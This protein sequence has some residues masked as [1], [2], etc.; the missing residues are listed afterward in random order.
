MG[1]FNDIWVF[2]EMSENEPKL[3]SL[4]LL[5][6]AREL[7][8]ESGS[9]A[10]PVICPNASEHSPET[11]INAL[12]TAIEEGCPSAL[13]FGSTPL[14]REVSAGLSAVMNL[15]I[16]SDCTNVIYRESD[17]DL[18]FIRPAFDG[19]LYASVSLDTSPQLGTFSTGIFPL[20]DDAPDIQTNAR[21]LSLASDE[22]AVRARLVKFIED[23][24]LADSNIEEA[25]ILVA[26]GRGVGSAEGFDKLRELALLLGGNIAAS[27][28]A[29]EEGWISRD[30]QVGATGKTVT[31]KI[32][33]AC[34]I[35][36]AVPHVVGMKDSET[37]IAINTDPTAPIFDVAHYGIVGDLHKVIPELIEIFKQTK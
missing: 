18:L 21:T 34:G 31:P 27:R 3:V 37:I 16:A 15:G 6:K 10:I 8:E 4:E 11:I 17:T 23:A 12:K 33:F 36:G 25:S 5:A 19:K 2:M 29:V 7:A 9:R 22:N 26:G 30:Y 35:S 13:L 14:G 1:K 20:K 28:A 24:G 32:Y